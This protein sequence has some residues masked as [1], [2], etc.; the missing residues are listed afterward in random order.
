M[1]SLRGIRARTHRFGPA[2]KSLYKVYNT[3]NAGPFLHDF[4][5]GDLGEL[6]K[7]R[8]KAAPAA[9]YTSAID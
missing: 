9:V 6:M 5:T 3:D 4:N 8:V 1:T 2:Q 7:K